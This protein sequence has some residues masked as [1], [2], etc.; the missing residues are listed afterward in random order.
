MWFI[1]KS[2]LK[3]I[4]VIIVLFSLGL[5]LMFVQYTTNAEYNKKGIVTKGVV[6]AYKNV[7]NQNTDS[8][9]YPI[10]NYHDSNG[11]IYHFTSKTLETKLGDTLD[12]VFLNNNPLQVRMKD[13]V[14][15]NMGYIQGGILLGVCLLFLVILIH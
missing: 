9:L 6:V 11:D 14:L 3:L 5:Y 13:K 12:V 4:F 15:K 7:S 2:N 10:I 1:L 8:E